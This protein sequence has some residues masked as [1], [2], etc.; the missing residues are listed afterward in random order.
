MKRKIHVASLDTVI[1]K[2]I[3]RRTIVIGRASQ[4]LYAGACEVVGA[5]CVLVGGGYS[6]SQ[7]KLVTGVRQAK[8]KKRKRKRKKRKK[9][10]NR[11][12]KEKEMKKIDNESQSAD[13]YTTPVSRI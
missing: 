6:Q 13:Q 1:A 12:R 10:N 7:Y 2:N 4:C 11:K 9:I 8:E 3:T 5:V